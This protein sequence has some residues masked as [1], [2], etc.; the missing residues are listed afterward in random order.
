M[1]FDDDKEVVSFGDAVIKQYTEN[2]SHGAIN[3]SDKKINELLEAK[4][5]ALTQRLEDEKGVL[6]KI[7]DL[8]GDLFG[9]AATRRPSACSRELQN[10]IKI[11]ARSQCVQ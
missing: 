1:S 6:D 4:I 10:Y 5:A 11:L 3:K 2:L 8:F 9:C 7:G